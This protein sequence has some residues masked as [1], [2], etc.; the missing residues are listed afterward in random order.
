MQNRYVYV[1][2]RAD[3]PSNHLA[4]QA[5]HAGIAATFA[6]GEPHKTH[7][8]LVLCVVKDEHELTEAFERLK[9]VGCRCC[10]YHEDDMHNQMTAVATAPLYGPERKPLRKFKLLR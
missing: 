3:L 5:V 9:E 4:V 7:P 10:A 8:H 1:I 6:Y 2:V